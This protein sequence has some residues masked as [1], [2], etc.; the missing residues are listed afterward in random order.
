MKIFLLTLVLA[1]LTGGLAR[2]GA[3]DNSNSKACQDARAAFAE[4][5]NVQGPNQWYQGHQGSWHQSGHEWQWRSSDGSRYRHGNT[6][7]QWSKAER[8]HAHD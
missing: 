8:T 2:A 6:G 3:C 7:W 4:H 5:H 1:T